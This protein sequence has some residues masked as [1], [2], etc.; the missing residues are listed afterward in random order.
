MILSNPITV[1][2]REETTKVVFPALFS[3]MFFKM[4]SSVLVST[5]DT[6]SSKIKIGLF[7]I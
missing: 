6:L 3:L 7:L 5:A 4:T 1:E 2:T